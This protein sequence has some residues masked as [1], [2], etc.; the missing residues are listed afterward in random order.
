MINASSKMMRTQNEKVKHLRKERRKNARKSTIILLLCYE[1]NEGWSSRSRR[2]ACTRNSEN[3]VILSSEQDMADSAYWW[4]KTRAY[5]QRSRFDFW[6]RSQTPTNR[7]NARESTLIE[8][9]LSHPSALPKRKMCPIYRTDKIAR[10]ALL[11]CLSPWFLT[12]SFSG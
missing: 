5:C 10:W 8:E 1:H 4:F 11:R 3:P 6:W 2:L 7:S 9:T 12:L